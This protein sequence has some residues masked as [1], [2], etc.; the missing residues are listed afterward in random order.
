MNISLPIIILFVI[1]LFILLILFY[2][3]C[4]AT[5]SKCDDGEYDYIVCGLGSAGAIIAS[6]LAN[7][8][9]RV[10]AIE[11]GDNRNN[12]EIIKNA[13]FST[14]PASLAQYSTTYSGNGL[15]IG[16]PP[17]IKRNEY[18]FGKM[19][20]GSTG[21]N[22]MARVRPDKVWH[23]KLADL[24]N[25]DGFTYNNFLPYYKKTETYIGSSQQAN[26]R[27]ENGKIKITQQKIEN[28][29]YSEWFEGLSQASGVTMLDDY[30]T[31]EA[32]VSSP[33]FQRSFYY[34]GDKMIR[35]WSGVYLEGVSN[36]LTILSNS[37]VSR[38]LFR[39]K[40]AIG[41]EVIEG[42][43]CR[44]YFCNKEI[45]ICNG[46]ESSCLL[47]RSG[48]GN[49]D[50]LSQYNIPV[51][52]ENNQVGENFYDHVGATPFVL[53]KPELRK[54]AFSVI[55]GH[56]QDGIIDKP[57]IPFTSDDERNLEFLFAQVLDYGED[58][59]EQQPIYCAT[60]NLNP[61]TRGSIHI[62]GPA[63]SEPIIQLDDKEDL[64]VVAKYIREIL[65]PYLSDTNTGFVLIPPEIL[66]DEDKLIDYLWDVAFT[67]GYHYVGQCSIGK[68]VDSK[69]KV[70]GIENVRI[71]DNSVYPII[72]PCHTSI[73]AQAIGFYALDVLF[74]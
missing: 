56:I 33:Y 5:T 53:L 13:S 48:I 37:N 55:L 10:L 31:G 40:K 63:M 44:P 22:Y 39:H 17:F 71:A 7:K 60:W 3:S 72:P 9:F 28:D 57:E 61:Q 29:D 69:L 23:Q 18:V 11:R 45:I 8:G 54:Y 30:N 49:K 16:V 26:Q 58:R 47:E 19:W 12:D 25:D 43:G 66:G 52:Y 34:D 51:I 27:G 38:I 42:D 74:E 14:I 21:V 64:R 68:V 15:A 46:L 67:R 41:V 20:G 24:V 36:R 35:S 65:V 59:N 1:L 2:V 62:G 32:L 50:I 73:T 4:N 6:E 70:L